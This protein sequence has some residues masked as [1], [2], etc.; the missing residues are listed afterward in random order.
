MVGAPVLVTRNL[1]V[2]LNNG[3][4]GAVTHCHLDYVTIRVTAGPFRNKELDVARIPHRHKH[5]AVDINIACTHIS[6]KLSF[7]M[8]INK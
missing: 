7:G 4:R 1:R 8:T 2:G 3:T 5:V 6:F